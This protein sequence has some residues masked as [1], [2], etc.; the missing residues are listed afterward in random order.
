[1]TDTITISRDLFERLCES[2]IFADEYHR[3]LDEIRGEIDDDCKWQ[4]I[5]N[6]AVAI[7]DEEK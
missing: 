7:R 6:E 5:R 3:S 4:K 1:M 2:A